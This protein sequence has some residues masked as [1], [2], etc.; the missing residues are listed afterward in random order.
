MDPVFVSIIAE[1]LFYPQS[2]LEGGD[3]TLSIICS[4]I[5]VETAFTQA[6]LKA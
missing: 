6:F 4:A 5:A 2:E 3:H 1:R